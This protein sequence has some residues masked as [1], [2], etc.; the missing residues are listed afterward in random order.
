MFIVFGEA[1]KKRTRTITIIMKSGMI[2][3]KRL[4]EHAPAKDKSRFCKKYF[5]VR[6]TLCE[7]VI[8]VILR[9]VFLPIV[10]KIPASERGNDC[11]FK[12][13]GMTVFSKSLACDIIP[14]LLK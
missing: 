9:G 13:T 7:K 3:N 12:V 10:A 1:C 6:K 11:C 14:K 8:N 5:V 2:E 4:N